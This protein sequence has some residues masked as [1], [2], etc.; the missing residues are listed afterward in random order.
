ME[1]AAVWL[2]CI[3]NAPQE[4]RELA[5]LE[6]M[7][8]GAGGI[9]ESGEELAAYYKPA[10]K[11]KVEAALGRFA[12]LH[13][14]AV[15][16]RWEEIASEDWWESWKKYFHPLK[17]SRR[18]WICPTWENIPP[19]EE[20]MATLL[21]DPGRAFGTGGHET[22]RLCLD[23]IDECLLSEPVDSMLDVGCGSG[24]LSIAARLLGVKKVGALDM[25]ILAAKATRDNALLNRVEEGI[26][27]YCGELRAIK[28]EWPLVVANI[29]YQ[30]V[31]GLAPLL[32]KHT[33]PGGRLIISG[34]LVE[35]CEGAKRYFEG[36]GFE[37]LERRDMGPWS[38]LLLRKN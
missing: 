10:D 34:F 17:A 33:A 12:A 13:G 28:G 16:V 22:T 36:L 38:A 20:G 7:E 14:E 8:L 2:K 24:I 15:K 26:E 9:E 21:I 19:P 37:T 11:E 35:E 30:I 29:L 27:V 23:M 5:A 1:E 31:L 3:V 25:D 18:L 4:L 32:A 6:L